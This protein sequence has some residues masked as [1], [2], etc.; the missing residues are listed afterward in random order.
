MNK[1]AEERR[2]S[3]K[4]DL[5]FKNVGDRIIVQ[6]NKENVAKIEAMLRYNSSY[7]NSFNPMSLGSSAYYIKQFKE[8]FIINKS[9]DWERYKYLLS[10]IINTIDKENSTHINS[11]LI[12]REEL[13]KRLTDL[14]FE[15]L[16]DYLKYPVKSSYEIIKILS[17]PTHPKDIM[18][19][20]SRKNFSFATKFCHYMCFY[21]FE[22][23]EEQDNFPIFDNVLYKAI[24]K[25]FHKNFNGDFLNY[26]A[27]IEIIDEII[28]EIGDEISRNGFDHLIRYVYKGNFMM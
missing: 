19:Y 12:G 6:L 14:S 5:S 3:S 11:D 4:Y 20:K 8:E 10:N 7:R 17:E 26:D 15:T 23:E 13:L 28:R 2:L 21:L 16:Y 24:K 27:Y 18:K 1:I 25:I 22:N 9:N